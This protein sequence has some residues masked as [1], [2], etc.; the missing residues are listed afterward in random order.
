VLANPAG[1]KDPSQMSI[2]ERIAAASNN[3]EDRVSDISER[4]SSERIRSVPSVRGKKIGALQGN[5]AGMNMQAMLG[6][7]R[8][9]PRGIPMM[10]MSGRPVSVKASI[11]GA[12]E[13]STTPE[14][15]SLEPGALQHAVTN[16]AVMGGKKKRRPKTKAKLNLEKPVEALSEEEKKKRGL[17]GFGSR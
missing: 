17:F 10:G 7:G 9:P 15:S 4:P 13:A 2:A 8:P 5:L 14:S 6:G 3:S 12:T 11:E 1:G 16:R